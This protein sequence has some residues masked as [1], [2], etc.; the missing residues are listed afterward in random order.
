[1][2]DG[3]SYAT[4]SFGWADGSGAYDAETGEGLV[5]FTGSITFT[6]HGGILNT[7]VADPRLRL[8]GDGAAHLILDVSGTTQEGVAIDEQ[9]VEFL[10]LEVETDTSGDELVITSTTAVLTAAGA[11]AFGTYP[12]GEQFDPITVGF[13]AGD[14]AAAPVAT[15]DQPAEVDPQPASSNTSWILWALLAALAVIVAVVA[16]VL[17]RRRK[18][19]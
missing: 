9:D 19:A 3:A 11:E 7:T 2:A 12:Q 5:S 14:C 8:D 4:P 17:V 15:P 6:G 18:T 13:D 16:V 10:E 1:M